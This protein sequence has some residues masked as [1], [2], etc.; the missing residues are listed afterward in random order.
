MSAKTALSHSGNTHR[1]VTISIPVDDANCMNRWMFTFNSKGEPVLLPIEANTYNL[2]I[3]KIMHLL[4]ECPAELN[5]DSK[6]LHA[7]YIRLRKRLKAT[8]RNN[9]WWNETGQHIY[10][11]TRKSRLRT[12]VTPSACGRFSSIGLE[13]VPIFDNEGSLNDLQEVA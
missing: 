13:E 11:S 9:Q 8:L 1:E 10:Q 12:K 3:G 7:L 4:S 2:P 5:I 6:A